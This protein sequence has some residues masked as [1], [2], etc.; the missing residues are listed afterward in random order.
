MVNMKFENIKSKRGGGERYENEPDNI[1][2]TSFSSNMQWFLVTGVILSVSQHVR[3]FT[4]H[5]QVF[6]SLKLSTEDLCILSTI[7]IVFQAR[8]S[9]KSFRKLESLKKNTN[10]MAHNLYKQKAALLLLNDQ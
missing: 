10:K 4:A 3:N 2:V 5:Q 7:S 9:L 1:G 6:H 8:N